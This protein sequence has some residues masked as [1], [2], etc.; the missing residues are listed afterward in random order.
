MS[1]P[2]PIRF[3]DGAAYEE[4]MGKWSRLAG[5]IFLEWVAPPP[6]LTWV[7]VGCGN[8]A[9]SELLASHAHAARINGVDPS[10]GQLAFARTRHKAG[11]AEFQ[12]GD[13]MKLP[14]DTSSADAAAMALVLFFVPEPAAG[15]AEMARVVRPGGIVCAYAWDIIGGG[16]PLEPIQIELRAMGMNPSLP[17]RPE[18]S[19][20]DVMHGLWSAAGLVEVETREIRVRRLFTNFEEYWQSCTNGPSLKDRV[21]AMEPAVAAD[22]RERVRQRLEAPTEGA[23]SAEAWANAVKG[24]VAG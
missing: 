22:L 18:A 20:I 17:P 21:A 14:F 12:I 8:G 5:E 3:N 10:E 19:R 15:V 23:F 4:L 1:D 16:F 11:V 9:F 13:A 6:A 2:Q 7:D 24:R